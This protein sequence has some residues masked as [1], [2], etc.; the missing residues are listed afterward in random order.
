MIKQTCVSRTKLER[1]ETTNPFTPEL[2]A[3]CDQQETRIYVGTA[4][5]EIY[6]C[7]VGHFECH[8]VCYIYVLFG[9]KGLTAM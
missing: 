9:T 8:T 4:Y 6:F 7:D 3:C 5:V 2:T 1:T